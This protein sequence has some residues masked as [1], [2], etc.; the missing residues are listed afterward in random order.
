MDLMKMGFVPPE[1]GLEMLNL[2][3]VEKV[4]DDY[5]VDI[6]QAQR[7][8]IRMAQSEQVTANDYDNHDVHIEIHNKYRKGQEYEALDDQAKMIYNDHVASHTQASVSGLKPGGVQI[9]PATGQPVP[10][11]MGPEMPEVV[12]PGM[13]PASDP[14]MDPNMQPPVGN[15]GGGEDPMA[16]LMQQM[17]AVPMDQP[18]PPN[19]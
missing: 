3:G 6:R 4:Y 12:E 16:Q 5:L 9:D 1:K 11:G 8:N 15:G 19:F 14:G 2:G 13:E 17:G 7:E 18:P 10:P